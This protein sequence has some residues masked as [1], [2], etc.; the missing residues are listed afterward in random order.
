MD[1]WFCVCLLQDLLRSCRE[2][3]SVE[4]F[5]MNA[6]GPD[7]DRDGQVIADEEHSSMSGAAD[8]SS[9]CTNEG[10]PGLIMMLFNLSAISSTDSVD[11]IELT[12]ESNTMAPSDRVVT[13]NSQLALSMACWAPIGT[14]SGLHVW[15]GFVDKNRSIW[16]CFNA[17]P[18][19]ANLGDGEVRHSL[20]LRRGK[21]TELFEDKK[22]SWVLTGA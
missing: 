20:P 12:W 14:L 21:R 18:T 11:L 6:A 1:S 16:V 4:V 5:N 9:C 19:F 3:C 7:V 2:G 13:K 10:W 8:D 22:D 17:L 15:L